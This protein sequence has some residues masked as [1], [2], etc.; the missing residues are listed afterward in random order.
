VVLYSDSIVD[1]SSTQIKG[2]LLSQITLQHDCCEELGMPVNLSTLS[3]DLA[4]RK[5][6]SHLNDLRQASKKVSEL[7]EAV[8]EQEWKSSHVIYRDT[9]SV[10]LILI[11]SAASVYLLYR[12]YGYVHHWIADRFGT[13]TVPA[14]VTEVS[15]TVEPGDR[16]NTVNSNNKTSN[17][18]LNVTEATPSSPKRALRLQVAK[19]HF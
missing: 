9:H 11:V 18:S 12:L 19:S 4:Y 8:K 16:G 3:L 13:N 17:D 7:M 14:P 6:A 2:D 1:N 15:S 10:L 5:T